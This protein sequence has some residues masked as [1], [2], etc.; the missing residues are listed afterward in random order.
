MKI[1]VANS[2]GFHFDE[3][4]AGRWRGTANLFD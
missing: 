1:G 4:F 3:D 2:A